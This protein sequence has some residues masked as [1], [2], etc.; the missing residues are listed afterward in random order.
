MR[1]FLSAPRLL[2]WEILI[3][4]R[5]IVPLDKIPYVVGGSDLSLRC[6]N[7]VTDNVGI[8]KDFPTVTFNAKESVEM[9]F[10]TSLSTHTIT[11]DHDRFLTILVVR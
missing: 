6:R 4:R 2:R 3:I 1:R 10:R 8:L 5:S 11:R 9:P 7:L